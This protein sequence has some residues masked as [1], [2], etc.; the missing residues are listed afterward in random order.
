M[1]FCQ[2]Q[3]I[4][5]IFFKSAI[6]A[7]KVVDARPSAAKSVGSAMMALKKVCK[8]RVMLSGKNTCVKKNCRQAGG[9]VIDRDR[10][11]MTLSVN[12]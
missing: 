12:G 5:Y 1:A 4:P 8:S 11:Q 9:F 2:Y 7:S 3:I 10:R 6:T